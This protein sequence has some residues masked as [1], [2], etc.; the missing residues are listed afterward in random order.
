LLNANSGFSI[1]FAL[2]EQ[3]IFLMESYLNIIKGWFKNNPFYF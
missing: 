1:A 2:L 3:K